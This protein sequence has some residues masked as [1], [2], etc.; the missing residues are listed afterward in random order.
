MTTELNPLPSKTPPSVGSDA[1]DAEHGIQLGLL[2]AARNSLEH[3]AGDAAGYLE[4]LYSYTQAHFMSEQLLMRLSA[5]ANFQ[6][7]QLEHEIL[8]QQLDELCSLAEKG[9]SG[10]ALP[11]LTEH[12]QRLLAH[13]RNW[14]LVFG[15]QSAP[16]QDG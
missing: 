8:L 5:P 3:Q 13:I 10:R 11:L 6:A 12:E 1:I 9:E 14:D 4:Q 16:R 7:H 2:E 15:D